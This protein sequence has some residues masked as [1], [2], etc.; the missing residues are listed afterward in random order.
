MTVVLHPNLPVVFA[1]LLRA[2]L[3]PKT[4]SVLSESLVNKDAAV[5]TA[6]AV[7]DV[8]RHLPGAS[9]LAWP[10]LAALAPVLAVT[11]MA[12]RRIATLVEEAPAWARGLVAAA[13]SSS[14]T[15]LSNRAKNPR[16]G[17]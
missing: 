14:L 16:G 7:R 17:T 5:V 8:V 9:L 1:D 13:L 3:F 12:D 2:G 15:G 6:V 4:N 10:A 11:G